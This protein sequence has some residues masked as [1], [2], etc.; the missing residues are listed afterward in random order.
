MVKNQWINEWNKLFSNAKSA[1]IYDPLPKP[2]VSLH[3]ANEFHETAATD[4]KGCN[5]NL[6]LYLIASLITLNSRATLIKKNA[7]KQLLQSMEHIWNRLL[8]IANFRIMS[9]YR[10]VTN[11]DLVLNKKKTQINGVH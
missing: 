2:A 10:G 11:G 4:L 7:K 5:G 9:F 6:T 8:V 1:Y 3:M